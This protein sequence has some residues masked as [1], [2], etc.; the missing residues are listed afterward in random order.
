MNEGR[1]VAVGDPRT[2]KARVGEEVLEVRDRRVALLAEMPIDG[3]VD[4]VRQALAE[5]DE[6]VARHAPRWRCASPP[7]TTSS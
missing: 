7:W 6:P 1:I 3:S 4:A 5:L 2:L